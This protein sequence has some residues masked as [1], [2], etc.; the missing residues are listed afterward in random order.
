MSFPPRHLTP[1]ELTVLVEAHFPQVHEGNGRIT[2][3]RADADKTVV[4]MAHD[5]RIVRPGGTV[6]GPTMFKLA[7]FGVYV[8]ILGRL[9][10]AGLQAVT[11]SMTV[12]FLSRPQPADMIAEIQL[13]KLGRRLAVAEARLYAAGNPEVIAHA[14]STYAIPPA[15]MAAV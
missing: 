10:E 1:A 11:T 2:I 15:G 3:E 14:T 12:N 7:D 13:L 9:G 5:P 8:A 6:S 4:R